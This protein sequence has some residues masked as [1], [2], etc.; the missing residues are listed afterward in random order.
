MIIMPKTITPIATDSRINITLRSVGVE[1][2]FNIP[3]KPI[4]SFWYVQVWFKD[5]RKDG[6]SNSKVVE[7]D[8]Y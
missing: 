6:F 1:K 5:G 2:I 4:I 8:M 3:N 7:P